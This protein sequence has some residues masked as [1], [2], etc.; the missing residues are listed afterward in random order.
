M[1]PKQQAGCLQETEGYALRCVCCCR[2]YVRS[3][4]L[5]SRSSRWEYDSFATPYV[6]NTYKRLHVFYTDKYN[7]REATGIYNLLETKAK[8]VNGIKTIYDKE[9]LN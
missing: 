2:Q 9:L 4:R 3:S 8:T 1:C 6:S 7:D 5:C